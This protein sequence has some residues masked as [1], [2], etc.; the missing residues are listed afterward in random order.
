VRLLP[1]LDREIDGLPGF[2]YLQ[3]GSSALAGIVIAGFVAV[4][5]R[6]MPSAPAEPARVP[7]LSGSDRWL[8]AAVIGG[9]AV[10]G[11]VRRASEWWDYWGSTAKP[12]EL[13][14]ALCFG[15]GA[16]LVLGLAVYAVGVRV[17]RPVPADP[18]AARTEPSRP[19]AR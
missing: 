12:W 19:A 7:E 5:L 1:V 11:A 16:G 18:A 2:W 13:I 9:C 14:P 6:R 17:W 10:A 15:G 8:A 3:Y 4:V